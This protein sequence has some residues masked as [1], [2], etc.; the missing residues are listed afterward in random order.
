MLITITADTN[1]ASLEFRL[2]SPLTTEQVLSYFEAKAAEE[3]E[4]WS[5][6]RRGTLVSIFV[7][8]RDV[9]HLVTEDYRRFLIPYISPI[10][11]INWMPSCIYTNLPFNTP[12]KLTNSTQTVTLKDFVNSVH[13]LTSEKT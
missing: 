7:P 1:I 3:K 10:E 13:L 2:N 12:V 11:V 4:R 9:I 8:R 5:F 6:L